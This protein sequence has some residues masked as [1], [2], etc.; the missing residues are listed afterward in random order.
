MRHVGR[1]ALAYMLKN[2]F[3]QV[4][5]ESARKSVILSAED[6][7]PWLEQKS[8]EDITSLVE[9]TR[10]GQVLEFESKYTCTYLSCAKGLL[11]TLIN[12]WMLSSLKA[13][14]RPRSWGTFELGLGHE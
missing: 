9:T 3:S 4:I 5:A 1:G 12:G 13:V 2:D 7:A 10:L 8:T 14:G 6:I 11:R